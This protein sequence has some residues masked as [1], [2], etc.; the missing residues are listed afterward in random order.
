MRRLGQAVARLRSAHGVQSK[1][2][3][4]RD[5]VRNEDHTRCR[6]LKNAYICALLGRQR[7][8]GQLGD[9]AKETEEDFSN[10]LFPQAAPRGLM[11]AFHRII[12]LMATDWPCCGGAA[13]TSDCAEASSAGARD[14][15]R[16]AGTDV[17]GGT[18]A[19]SHSWLSPENVT[20]D[21]PGE[22]DPWDQILRGAPSGKQRV[23]ERSRCFF[24]PAVAAWTVAAAHRP[25]S[26]R[27]AGGEHAQ[28]ELSGLQ[29]SR[30][31]SD[32]I[33]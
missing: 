13:R 9:L 28:G 23:P 31:V 3:S 20:L 12:M 18:C 26:C 25:R 14:C 6:V 19:C 11:A 5:E 17:S 32:H 33:L 16:K 8:R 10:K 15:G 7:R 21:V 1:S 4:P 29:A 2:V 24:G 27:S 30:C 22:E